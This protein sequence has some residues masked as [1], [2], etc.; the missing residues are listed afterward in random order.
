MQ[1]VLVIGAGLAGL[2][3]A[4]RLG[5]AGVHVIVLE[6]RD[7]IGGRVHTIRDP[8][9]QSPVELG[10]EFVHG[11]PGEIWSMVRQEK[12]RLGTVEGHHWCC[13][14]QRLRNCDKFWSQWKYV[15]RQLKQGKTF[16]DRTFAEYI[17]GVRAD[18][19]TKRVSWEYVEGFNAAPADRIS[20]QFLADG[21]QAADKTSGDKMFRVFDGLDSIVHVLSRLDPRHVEL[22]LSTPVSAIEWRPGFVRAGGFAAESAIVTLPLGVLQAGTVRFVPSIPKKDAAVAQLAMGPVVKAILC[23]HSAFWEERGLTDLAFL[24]ARGAAFPIWWTT[25]P[26][27]EPTLVGWAAGPAAEKFAN[28]SADFILDTAVRSLAETLKI[29]R[30]SLE[31]RLRA[32]FVVDWQ[33]DPY[34]MG[35]YSYVPVSAIT[36]PMT[37]AEPVAGTL[38]F[39]GEATDSDG[40]SG[41]MQGAIA[42]GIRAADEWLQANKR[43]AA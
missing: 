43:Q 37:L 28:Q 18:P 33:A 25:R 2:A 35:A 21:Q 3:A 42:S 19:E 8:R 22:H 34:A 38:F 7:R 24:H 20:V 9:V 6:A 4:R 13:E 15:A 10:A 39:A 11:K 41:T 17:A 14:D 23:F 29:D 36:A 32:A 12:M 26:I 40:N 5:S 1:S 27:A 16:P 30:H 31:S